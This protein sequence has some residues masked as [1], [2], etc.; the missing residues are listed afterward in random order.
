MCCPQL[1]LTCMQHWQCHSRQS[2]RP[3]CLPAAGLTQGVLCSELHAMACA[4]HPQAYP[5][6]DD[7]SVHALS[8]ENKPA[9]QSDGASQAALRGQGGWFVPEHSRG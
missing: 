4:E 9:L 5:V 3:A 6:H 1:Q 7:P 2:A 8:S